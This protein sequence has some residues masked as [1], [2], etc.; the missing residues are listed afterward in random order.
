MTQ[1]LYCIATSLLCLQLTATG[2][3]QTGNAVLDLLVRK[4][5]I[6]DKE[7]EETQAQAEKETAKAIEA[8]SKL[9]VSSFVKAFDLYGD[10][11][12][13]SEY[14]GV[15]TVPDVPADDW[16]YMPPTDDRLRFRGRA[17]IGTNISFQ[18]WGKVGV[19]L[20]TSPDKDPVSTNQTFQDTFTKK[21]VYFDLFCA[22]L[23]PPWANWFTVTVGKMNNPIWQPHFA[24]PMEYDF[25]VTPEGLAEQ[26]SLKLGPKQEWRVFGNFLQAPLDE[27]GASSADPMLY[28]FQAGVEA[29]LG[30]VEFTV[31]G[32]AYFTQNLDDMG[33]QNSGLPAASASPNRGNLAGF[34]PILGGNTYADDFSVAYGRADVAWAFSEKPFLGTPCVLTFSGEYMKNLGG[35]FEDER[36]HD[37]GIAVVDP[38]QTEAYT[39][40]VAFGKAKKTGEWQLAYQYKHLEADATWDAVTD[41]DWG[42]GGTDRRGHVVKLAYNMREWWQLGFAAFV[43]EKISHRLN[44]GNNTRGIEGEDLLRIQ[45]D[46]VFKF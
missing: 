39:A 38:D 37:T 36:F 42:Y 8:N 21:E 10:I 40:Q 27:V 7:A 25:D 22:Q 13:R 6:T 12:M 20:T 33:I 23:T 19:R 34:N 31:A 5:V 17:R 44:S 28:E 4:G 32:G 16:R 26:I 43:T 9:K 1:G 29:D 35:R 14:F 45:V 15:E 30:P 24:S 46:S 41:S 11:R 3:A 18:D 2:V